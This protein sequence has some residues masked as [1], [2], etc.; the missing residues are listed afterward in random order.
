MIVFRIAATTR[1]LRAEA[2]SG[3]GA[4]ATGGR[5]NP[6]TVPMLYCGTTL[7]LSYLEM[8]VHINLAG[9]MPRNRYRIEISFPPAVWNKRRIARNDADFPTDWDAHPSGKGSADYGAKWVRAAREAV[10]VVPSV[11]IP[12]EE[13]VLINPRHPDFVG[14][15]AINQGRAEYDHRLFA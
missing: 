4:A 15:R 6:R 2:I 5:W 12:Q 11:I 1:D 3:A 7:A 10:L 14:V 9:P 13:N 8:L